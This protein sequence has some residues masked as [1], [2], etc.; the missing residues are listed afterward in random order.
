MAYSPT[1]SPTSLNTPRNRAL[2]I[3]TQRS[4]F[5]DVLPYDPH[6]GAPVGAPG[7]GGHY[8]MQGPFVSTAGAPIDTPKPF[9]IK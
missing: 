6:A 5:P 3:G 8:Q 9:G 7:V 2:D 4:G 1:R